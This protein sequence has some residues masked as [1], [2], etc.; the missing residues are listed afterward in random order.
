MREDLLPNKELPL[1]FVE[2]ELRPVGVWQVDL[3]D[4]V[5]VE[6]FRQLLNGADQ[7]SCLGVAKSDFRHLWDGLEVMSDV[8]VGE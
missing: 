3:H 7:V 1:A 2:V 5:L 4:A 6:G 8:Q